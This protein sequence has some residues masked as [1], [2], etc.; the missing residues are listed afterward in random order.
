VNLP[1]ILAGPFTGASKLFTI[2]FALV[3]ALVLGV[4]L[5]ITLAVQSAGAQASSTCTGKHVY[6]TQN[7]T[8]VAANSPKGTT[9]CIHDGTYNIS[10]PVRVEGTDRFIGLYNDSTRPAVVTSKAQQVFNAGPS[11]GAL[12]KG[13]KISGAVGGNYCEPNCGRGIQGGKNLTVRNAWIT[14]NK[15][16]G[17]GGTSTG[18]RVEN[19]RIDH[20][21][22]YS[23]SY[24]D[25]QPS[26]AAGI[27]SSQSGLTVVNSTITDNYWDGVWCD[28]D[29][30]AVTVK[31]S[32]LTGNG[33]SGIHAEILSG[34]AVFSGNTI[35]GNGRLNGANHPSGLLIVSSSNVD[36]YN[37]TFGNNYEHGVRIIKDGRAPGVSN[38][39]I[40]DNTMSGDTLSGCTL[41]GVSCQSNN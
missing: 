34:P 2:A 12:I 24:L 36:A 26:T 19:S 38:V 21:G 5:L 28:N 14:N 32:T 13:L 31:G 29:C 33:K 40:H 27:K 18:L 39:K 17:I 4:S 20:N 8:T 3:V 6:P 1:A 35:K 16:S 25:G 10:V 37:N 15:N 9:F 7:L 23:F 41:S 22:S 11:S 30:E